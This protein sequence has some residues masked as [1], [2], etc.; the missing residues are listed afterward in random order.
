MS[1]ASLSRFTVPLASNQ[2]SATQG[3]LMPKLKYRFRV[4]FENFGTSGSTVELTKQVADAARPN[5][6]FADQ[7]LEVYNSKIHY[8]GKP[9]W[10]PVTIKL[11]DDVTNAVTKLVG[12]QNQKQFDFF[13]QASATAGGDY[14]FITRIEMLDGGN[15]N[16]GGAGILETWVLYGCY[17]A[18][19][20]YEGLSYTGAA[21]PMMITLSI[22]YDNAQ[23][24]GIGSAMGT[25]GFLQKR[26]TGTTGNGLY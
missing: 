16:D 1:I 25:Q 4:S 19:T 13:E 20:N 6:K 5:V 24:E 10:D 2:S 7:T 9:T 8:A 3:L 15:G 22:Q 17:L 11:R 26:G 12:E 14:K 23:Q 18:S 21:D